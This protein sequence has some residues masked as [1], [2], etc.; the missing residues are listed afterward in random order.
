MSKVYEV[1]VYGDLPP[2]VGE[3]DEG[4]LTNAHAA[5][6]FGAYEMNLRAAKALA[7]KLES[8]GLFAA[9]VDGETGL[10]AWRSHELS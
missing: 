9:V 2:A 1:R 4:A 7:R 3:E 8:F 5:G 6:D 10:I